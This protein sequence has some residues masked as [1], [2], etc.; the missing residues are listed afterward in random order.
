MSQNNLPEFE[1]DKGYFI[2]G[3]RGSGK[4]E[5]TRHLVRLFASGGYKVI[6]LDVIGNLTGLKKEYPKE[7]ELIDINPKDFDRVEEIFKQLDDQGKSKKYYPLIAVLDEADRYSYGMMKKT[8]LSD[9][10]N[11]G[12]NY[13]QGYIAV[14]RRTAD[15]SKDF[16]TQADYAFIFQLRSDKEI[17]SVQDWLGLSDEEA[18][19]L[20]YLPLHHFLLWGGSNGEVLIPNA[21]LDL[22]ERRTS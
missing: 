18:E 4:T 19:S 17:L 5:L 2:L 21:V 3:K 15:I 9:Y 22:D 8:Y 10:I 11:K 1:I 12:R 7:V 20:K 16:P 6:V 13:G 14:T